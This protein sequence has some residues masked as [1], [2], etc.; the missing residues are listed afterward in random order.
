MSSQVEQL[1][2][3]IANAFRSTDLSNP[4]SGNL[5]ETAHS[6]IKSKLKQVAESD[7]ESKQQLLITTIDASLNTQVATV[8][9]TA[10]VKEIAAVVDEEKAIDVA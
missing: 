5:E 1:A 10:I 4:S 8:I 7:S 6:F 9:S 2:V 3:E